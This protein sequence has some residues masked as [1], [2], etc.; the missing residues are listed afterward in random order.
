MTVINGSSIFV[1][2]GSITSHDNDDVINGGGLTNFWYDVVLTDTPRIISQSSPSRVTSGDLISLFYTGATYKHD[3]MVK[4]N[5]VNNITF[6][7]ITASVSPFRIA[8]INENLI[9]HVQD[10]VATLT[11]TSTNVT[12][13]QRI[14]FVTTV[15]E[16]YYDIID[17]VSGSARENATDNINN[18]LSYDKNVN[19][20]STQSDS[21]EIY[22]R[23]TNCWAYNID[24]TCIS[25][26]NQTGDKKRAGTL[27]SP[28]H[29]IF[30]SH[31]QI[32]TGH[33]V[34]FV[35]S[36]NNVCDRTMTN[37]GNIEFWSDYTI[38]ILDSEV[39]AGINYCKVISSDWEDY[40]PYATFNYVIAP[41][42]GVPYLIPDQQKRATISIAA[43]SLNRFEQSTNPLQLNF[44]YKKVD[45]DS[46][47][48]M[49]SI[50]NDELILM[51]TLFN[52]SGSQTTLSDYIDEI[53][54]KMTDLNGGDDTYQ[55]DEIDLSS[56]IN[57]S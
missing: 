13:T 39:D 21:E 12:K 10:G 24:L 4:I 30:A 43:S 28:K 20:F 29:I 26:W 19:I 34:R 38:G 56:F 37:K 23:N 57:F 32:T 9:T 11:T 7:E 33:T 15:D 50:I 5:L 3:Q 16:N 1:D 47:S 18:L 22:V 40:F 55:L 42:R 17:D 41:V 54:Q 14:D 46:G 53:N 27:I 48:P 35:D 2:G 31:Y 6:E 8:T 52:D 51:N 44:Y 49:F 25:P 36:N 45:G